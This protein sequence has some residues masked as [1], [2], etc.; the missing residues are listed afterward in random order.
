MSRTTAEI[1]A[2]R[3]ERKAKLQAEADAQRVLDLEA[4]DA[5]E[6]Q[7]GDTNVCYVDV[8][9]TP[10]LPTMAQ[11]RMPKGIELKRYREALKV[12][13][14]KVDIQ[15]ANEAAALLGAT[16]CVYPDKDVF[17][18]MCEARPDLK[19]QLGS[20]ATKLAQGKAAEEGKD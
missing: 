9:Y 10:G 5:N 2:D 12:N 11:G 16:V 13:G 14:E 19:A 20:R 15:A 3:A 18:K 17:A 6:I 1:Q 7:Y 8:P 4:L